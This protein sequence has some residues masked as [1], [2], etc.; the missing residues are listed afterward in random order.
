MPNPVE[1]QMKKMATDLGENVYFD[2]RVRTDAATVAD[3][4]AA[5]NAFQ[6]QYL[7]SCLG[8]GTCCFTRVPLLAIDV[9]RY[10]AEFPALTQEDQPLHA[11]FACFGDVYPSGETLDMQLRKQETGACVFLDPQTKA[12][13][14]YEARGLACQTY[15][16]LPESFLAK[17]LRS[18]I[19]NAG[20]DE[21]IRRY[22]TEAGETAAA[23]PPNAFS[24]KDRYED[25]LLKEVVSSAL[26]EKVRQQD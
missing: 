23:Y 10:L 3:Y 4:C 16:C 25:V 18:A 21:L 19:V 2:I 20:M 5:L 7:Q 12:C 15:F 13:R 14:H 26:W 6:A 11:F 22:L 1:I 8:C 17:K 24:A 9:L